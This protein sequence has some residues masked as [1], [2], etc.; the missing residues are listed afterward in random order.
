VRPGGVFIVSRGGRNRSA[1]LQAVTEHF[2][3]EAGN[4]PWPP[5][6]DS[7][8]AV[9]AHMRDLGVDERPL[10]DLGLQTLVSVEQV[11]ANLEAGYWAACW[12]IDSETRVRAATRT[13]EW[14]RLEFGDLDDARH[15]NW[16]SSTWHAYDLPE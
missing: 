8:E 9:D 2:F 13:R 16:E 4:P 3:S 11:I 6:A 10:P 1:W 15:A 14:A 7:I 12:G 5:G